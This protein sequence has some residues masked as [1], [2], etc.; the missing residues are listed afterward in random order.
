MLDILDYLRVQGK[1]LGIAAIGAVLLLTVE[2]VLTHFFHV[3]YITST[4]AGL[5][6][7]FEWN[8]NIQIWLKMLN[9]K[10]V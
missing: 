5:A 8:T 6:V 3:F 9:V 4:I 1:V 7:S 2:F 10:R